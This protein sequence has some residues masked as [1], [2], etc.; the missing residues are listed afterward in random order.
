MMERQLWEL[1]V[2]SSNPAAPTTYPSI[3]GISAMAPEAPK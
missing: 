2:A 1:D 3:M